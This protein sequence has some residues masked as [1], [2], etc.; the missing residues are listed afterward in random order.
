[1]TKR[2]QR[3]KKKKSIKTDKEKE[4]DIGKITGETNLPNLDDVLTCTC[5]R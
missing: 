4:K 1:M 3:N 2:T 5:K